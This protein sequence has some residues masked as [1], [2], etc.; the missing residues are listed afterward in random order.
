[1]VHWWVLGHSSQDIVEIRHHSSISYDTLGLGFA[2]AFC[3]GWVHFCIG[4]TCVRKGK[5][6]SCLEQVDA[7]QDS[8]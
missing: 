2:T 8:R 6:A 7:K 1:M 4:P 5:R 3:Q